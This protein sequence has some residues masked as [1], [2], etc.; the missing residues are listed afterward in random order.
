[1]NLP[2]HIRNFL[3]THGLAGTSGVVAVS[4]G[5]DSVALA[6]ALSRAGMLKRIV[7]AHINHQLRG[8]ESDGD[9]AFVASLPARWRPDDPAQ[10]TCR[11]TRFDTRADA[12]GDNLEAVARRQRYAWL[13]GIARQEGAVWVAAAH[14]ADDQAETVL[15]RL[16][17]GSGLDGLRGMPT[18]RPLEGA[19]ELIRPLL[20]VR[21]LD[22]LAYLQAE[23]QP[24]REDSSNRDLSF[25]RNRIR[26]E[27]IPR[28]EA[29]YNPA[30][31]ASLCRL[32]EQARE[33]QAEMHALA[34]DLLARAELPRAANTL[35]FRADVL[36]AAPPHR[37]RELFRQVWTREG[38]P[39]SAMG[40]DE[41]QRLVW[42]VRG[43]VPAWDL[44]A[45][46]HARR[47]GR[48]IQLTAPPPGR[49]PAA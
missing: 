21:R 7:L 18:R 22:V 5:P 19:I 46:V 13:A 34:T 47:Q 29:D 8:V 32:A 25:T 20:T 11:V 44:P 39:Q 28:L 33:V 2:I 12:R 30:V 43:E 31:V 37:V 14:T 36:S 3:E 24:Y 9:E 6:N 16:L 15:F 10:L 40:F 38:W 17:R 4:G 1:M 26:H 45:G 48:V 42:L 49:P 23:A 27:L 41:W 35:V